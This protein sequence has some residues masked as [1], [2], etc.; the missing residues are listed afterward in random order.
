MQ[1]YSYYRCDRLQKP[2]YYGHLSVFT[3]NPDR[4]GVSSLSGKNTSPRQMKLPGN[5]PDI[6]SY[7]V[8]EVPQKLVKATP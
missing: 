4:N 1:G 6:E 2:S 3:H 5:I 7:Q 8:A